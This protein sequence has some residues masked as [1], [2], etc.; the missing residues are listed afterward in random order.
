MKKMRGMDDFDKIYC[1]MKLFTS[2]EWGKFPPFK[3]LV[4]KMKKLNDLKTV[5]SLCKHFETHVLLNMQDAVATG[6]CK[7]STVILQL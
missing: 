7:W 3:K 2:H 5:K 6:S 1:N 4:F